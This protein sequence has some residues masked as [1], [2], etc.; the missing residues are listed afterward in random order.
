MLNKDWKALRKVLKTISKINGVSWNPD[1]E[2]N[3]TNTTN[4]IKENYKLQEHEKSSLLDTKSK[5]EYSVLLALKNKT[6]LINLIATVG[7][8]S[9]VIFD[10][11][12]INFYL[13][14]VGGSI[15]LNTLWATLSWLVSSFATGAMQK[16]LDTKKAL[17]VNSVLPAFTF[18]PLL[19]TEDRTY[20]A[21]WFFISR[22]FNEGAFVLVYYLNSEMFP[23]LFVP[24]SFSVCSFCSRLLT[25]AA[26]QIAEIKPVQ[27]PILVYIFVWFLTC[28]LV[29]LIQKP[30]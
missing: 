19:F 13:K 18:C 21:V 14:Y 27:V 9:L 7:W 17:I 26:P 4:M 1:Y 2:T 11:Y 20:I 12:M 16:W 10:Y 3:I 22:F 23:P 29:L 15:Y 30:S 25:M 8:F 24:F 28:L 5:D 6:I